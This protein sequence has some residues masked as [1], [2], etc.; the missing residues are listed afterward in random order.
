VGR[1]VDMMDKA[2]ALT[3]SPPSQQ[4]QQKDN[5]NRFLAASSGT[6]MYLNFTAKLSH[7]VGTPPEHTKVHPLIRSWFSTKT[8][9]TFMSH[10]RNGY[11]IKH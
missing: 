6:G 9:K 4:Q 11:L 3:T 7:N 5:A 1:L 10:I 2:C 8:K